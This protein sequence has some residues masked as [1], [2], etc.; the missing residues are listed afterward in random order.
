L[1]IAPPMTAPVIA[2]AVVFRWPVKDSMFVT[3]PQ[4][5]QEA[6]TAVGAPT[7]NRQTNKNA[8]SFFI[9]CS[10]KGDDQ[11]HISLRNVTAV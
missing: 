5:P 9:F 10:P 4:L 6:R 11:L 8:R 7:A 3:R 1:P 2:P